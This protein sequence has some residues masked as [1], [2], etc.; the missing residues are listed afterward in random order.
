MRAIS[1]RL[2][3]HIVIALMVILPVI[4]AGCSSAGADLPRPTTPSPDPP[5]ST[6]LPSLTEPAPTQMIT[7]MDCTELIPETTRRQVKQNVDQ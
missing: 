3:C 4:L 6:P 5:T 2:N 7:P 1:K